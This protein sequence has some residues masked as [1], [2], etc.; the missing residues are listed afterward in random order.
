MARCLN[1]F[2]L[3]A[4]VEEGD[5]S[6]GQA[7]SVLY[8]SLPAPLCDDKSLATVLC[9]SPSKN[10]NTCHRW[11]TFALTLCLWSNDKIL[12]FEQRQLWSSLFS[13]PATL[14]EFPMHSIWVVV[15][16]KPLFKFL[17]ISSFKRKQNLWH[18]V[19]CGLSQFSIRSINSIN[20]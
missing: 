18:T 14:L 1:C 11:F 3:G 7:R 2:A 19:R 8:A 13:R 5:G 6:R 10:V 17:T 9:S 15:T 20:L 4:P 16:S 12:E